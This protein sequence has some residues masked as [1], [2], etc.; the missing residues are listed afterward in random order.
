MWCIVVVCALV[1]ASDPD[2][3]RELV[4]LRDT[5]TLSA[6]EQQ[7][8][9]NL[10]NYGYARLIARRGETPQALK[11]Y[12]RLSA[13]APEALLPKRD[14]VPLYLELGR[15]VAAAR[16]AR[17]VLIADPTDIDTAH[18]LGRLL[19]EARQHAEAA[20]VLNAA[21]QQPGIGARPTK[22][23]SIC[24]DAAQATTLAK[25]PSAMAWQAVVAH[26]QRHRPKLIAEGTSEQDFERELATAYERLGE[27]LAKAKQPAA[28]RD[29]LLSASAIYADPNRANDRAGALRL[30]WNLATLYAEAGDPAQAIATLERYLSHQPTSASPYERLAEYYRQ[31]NAGQQIVARLLGHAKNLPASHPIHDLILAEQLADPTTADAA[32]RMILASINERGTPAFF[33]VVVP[34]YARA[35][36]PQK[37]IQLMNQLFPA[38]PNSPDPARKAIVQTPAEIDRQQAFVAAVRTQS[39]F[40]PALIQTAK[41]DPANVSPAAWELLATLA[42]QAN[43]TNAYEVALRLALRQADDE[44]FFRAFGRYRSFLM[45]NRRF[46][47][48]I[49]LCESAAVRRRVGDGGI[50]YY[51]AAPYAEMGLAED[52]LSAIEQA[53]HTIRFES[54]REKVH[55]YTIVGKYAD[56]LKLTDA[57]LTEFREVDQVQSIRYLRSESYLGL[58][59]NA[60]S[61]AELRGILEEN[62]D[63]VL[64]LNNLGY[65]LADQ[66]RKLPEAETLIRRAI[67]VD[68]FERGRAGE[69]ILEHAA[70]L[71][72]LGWVKFRQGQL[73]QAREILERAA[74]LPEGATDPTVWDHLG[75]VAFRQGDRDRA[76]VAWGKAAVQFQQGHLGRYKGRA[77]DVKSKLRRTE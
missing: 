65:N 39:A 72:S 49:T 69:P 41:L 60:D 6:E 77:D 35:N 64:A 23:L 48:T 67:E 26:L 17:E 45:R 38:P 21:R 37:L 22:G 52:A 5:N 20:D 56:A 19:Y 33:R 15:D 58:R 13:D 28:A 68:R 9:Q 3:R 71:D 54:L 50:N 53:T 70:Y 4:P 61:E 44:H 73:A 32:Q 57:M 76:A 46:S 75:D 47:E 16:V 74:L 12:E 62:P 36:A 18:R 24:K 2:L 14:L 66:N 29:A 63:D 34:G 30:D 7:T 59:R 1:P 42:E 31:A 25:R 8:R 43:E 51:R 10:A 11:H 40:A 55:V 27:S